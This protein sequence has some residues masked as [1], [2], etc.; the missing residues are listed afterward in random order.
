MPPIAGPQAGFDVPRRDSLEKGGEGSGERGHRVALD[1]HDVGTGALEHAR[2]LLQHAGRHACRRLPRDHEVEIVVGLEAEDVEHLVE[3]RP[4]LRGYTDQTLEAGGVGEKGTYDR[5]HL[6]R[7]R[8]G[9]EDAD[10][11]DHRAAATDGSCSATDC[12]V[13][14][15]NP[16]SSTAAKT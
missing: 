8:P 5:G 16:R 11:T 14:N 7:L 3:H 2:K 4:V 10:D 1:E 6:D 15:R 9:A 12:I 13:T